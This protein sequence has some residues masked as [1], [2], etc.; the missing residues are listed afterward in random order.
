MYSSKT[1]AWLTAGYHLF[2]NIRN[3]VP[4]CV[5]D[6]KAVY[7]EPMWVPLDVQGKGHL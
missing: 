3:I 2:S 1:I 4:Y 6:S 5:A 7:K